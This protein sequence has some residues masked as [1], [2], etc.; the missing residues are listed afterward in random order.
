MNK[1]TNSEKYWMDIVDH[2]AKAS[3]CRVDVGCVLMKHFQIVGTGYVGSVRGDHHCNDIGCMLV[4]TDIHG[5][6][7]KK[8]SC[9]NT[10]HAELNAVLKC[11]VRDQLFAFCTMQ[12]CLRCLQA[13]LQIGVKIIVYQKPYRD[14]WRDK[15]IAETQVVF[16]IR[17]YEE[18]NE[19]FV[20]KSMPY[21]KNNRLFEDQSIDKTFINWWL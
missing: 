20:S 19:L 14:V 6:S 1:T 10:M 21:T 2:I 8:E 4:Q 13:M 18:G 9:I 3:T 11:Q 16:D 17:E 15:Y 7:E 5:S 12:P